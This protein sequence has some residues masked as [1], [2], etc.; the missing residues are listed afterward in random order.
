MGAALE[1]GVPVV[2]KTGRMVRRGGGVTFQ[3]DK[4]MTQAL[5]YIVDVAN[6]QAAVPAADAPAV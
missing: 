6:S 4:A 5:G 2:L 1:A 3:G